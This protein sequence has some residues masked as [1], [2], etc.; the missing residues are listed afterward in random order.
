MKTPNFE[1][2][3]QD[4]AYKV[5]P[6][7]LTECFQLKLH[8]KSW[9]ILTD[10]FLESV[11]INRYKPDLVFSTAILKV[12]D[13]S[14]Q[15]TCVVKGKTVGLLFGLSEQEWSDVENMCGNGQQLFYRYFKE[16][17]SRNF[18]CE[19]KLFY[20]FCLSNQKENVLIAL[21]CRTNNTRNKDKNDAMIQISQLKESSSYILDLYL[22]H[23]RQQM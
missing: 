8:S 7:K 4:F 2:E 10:Y 9:G 15:V 13:G 17:L 21:F 6:T 3:F 5:A 22:N 11:K 16:G 1:K 23:F 20:N 19:Q 18:S 14:K 12:A